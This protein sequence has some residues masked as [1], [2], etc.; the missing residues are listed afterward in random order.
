[1]VSAVTSFFFVRI[2]RCVVLIFF[3][4]LY[5]KC[6]LIRHEIFFSFRARHLLK[7]IFHMHHH[8]ACIPYHVTGCGRCFTTHHIIGTVFLCTS[9]DVCI[10]SL[11]VTAGSILSDLIAESDAANFDFKADPELAAGKYQI[12]LRSKLPHL[13]SILDGHFVAG[14]RIWE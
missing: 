11:C 14:Y 9:L 5:A 1:M 2:P 12:S 10:L 6:F 13:A 7:N 8:Y 4:N 3:F